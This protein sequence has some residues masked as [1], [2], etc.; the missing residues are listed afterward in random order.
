[1]RPDLFVASFLALMIVVVTASG[2]ARAG[3][4]TSLDEAIAEAYVNNRSLDAERAAARA[5]D[6][7]LP[8]AKAGWR[9]TVSIAATQGIQHCQGTQNQGEAASSTGVCGVNNGTNGGSTNLS[10]ETYGLTIVQPVYKGG[11]QAEASQ[12]R[13]LIASER[14]KLTSTEQNVFLSTVT[15]F[16]D[17][18]LAQAE[19]KLDRDAVDVVRH[20]WDVT[21]AQARVGEVTDTDVKQ[22]EAALADA[23]AQREMASGKVKES[24]AALAHDI[25]MPVGTLRDPAGLP[26]LPP[27]RDAAISLAAREN[28][29]VVT[30][31]FAEMGT[32]EDIKQIR[33]ELLPTVS[34]N[35]SIERDQRGRAR[36]APG[37][38]GLGIR[39]AERSSLWKG[40]ASIRDRAKRSRPPPSKKASSTTRASPPCR[41]PPKIGTS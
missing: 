31:K 27:D 36:G 18:V 30:A 35:A 5:V 40:E 3:D 13:D 25:G 14:A 1:M 28:P 19:L 20:Q 12:A 33:G 29:D 41:R 8:Q 23:L 32:E 21:R 39:S 2:P 37:G 4:V 38:Y 16:M 11:L 9:P 24:A 26:L 10:P 15:S 34:L 6:E 22:A 7:K 17:T